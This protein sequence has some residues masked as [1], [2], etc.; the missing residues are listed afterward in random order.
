MGNDDWEFYAERLDQ[1]MLAN[2]I[3][4][5]KRKVTVFLTIIGQKAYALL[6]NLVAPTKPHEKKYENLTKAMM[7]HLKTEVTND[8]RKVQI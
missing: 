3:D 4:D 7:N 5:E 6:W 2:G 8:C 1:F